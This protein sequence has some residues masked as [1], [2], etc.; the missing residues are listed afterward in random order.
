MASQN[1]IHIA[2]PADDKIRI[3]DYLIGV[4]T[5]IPSRK[6]IKKAIR[7]ER[8]LINGQIARSGTWVEEGMRIELVEDDPTKFP[9]YELDLQ[10]VYEDDYF[11]IVN[12]PAGLVSSGNQ[13]RTLQNA[14]AAN[15]KAS[16]KEDAIY[17][18]KL[19]HRLDSATSGLIIVAKNAE[20]VRILGQMLEKQQIKKKYLAIVIGDSKENDRIDKK[21]HDKEALSILIK[22]EALRSE[23]FGMLS[24]VELYPQSG[25]THQLRIHMAEN[26]HPILGDRLYG[27]RVHDLKGKGLFLVALG[28][29]FDHPASGNKMKFEIPMPK[30]FQKYWDGLRKRST[31]S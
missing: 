21:I 12:K 15:L 30:K 2:N 29:E 20:S 25:R 22:K 18:P 13:L 4:F 27:N 31:S 8:I 16:A 24:L 19:V 10:V 17:P 6:S 11:A 9:N 28:L 7:K 3:N 1:E 14:V 5:S 23:K 26:N